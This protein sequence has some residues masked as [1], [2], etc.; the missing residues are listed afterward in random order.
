[1]AA[2]R[3]F[4][5]LWKIRNS[6]YLLRGRIFFY[7]CNIK[8]NRWILI[9]FM[10]WFLF[11]P[12]IYLNRLLSIYLSNQK[13]I[14]LIFC[15]IKTMEVFFVSLDYW[16][17]TNNRSRSPQKYTYTITKTFLSTKSEFFDCFCHN[18]IFFSKQFV[19]ECNGYWEGIWI[20]P[21]KMRLKPYV[22]SHAQSHIYHG[23][24]VL[25]SYV[26]QWRVKEM[27]RV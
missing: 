15:L 5:K 21:S 23:E 2:D 25:T 17:N 7:S 18:S 24:S 26:P 19:L 8:T 9:I 22:G 3:M 14:C 6:K 13:I 27:L 10:R 20:V 16:I 12:F 1:M 11:V 4:A